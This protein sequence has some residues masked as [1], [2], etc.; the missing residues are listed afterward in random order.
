MVLKFR[1][2]VHRDGKLAQENHSYCPSSEEYERYKKNWY[3]SEQIRQKCTDETPIRLPRSSY[4][5]APSSTAN[6]EMSDLNQF[7]FINTKGGIRLLLPVPHGG[8]GMK[9][10]GAHIF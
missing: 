5:Y 9:T 8:S 7:V 2:E 10:G 4:K 3:I 6:L 1:G